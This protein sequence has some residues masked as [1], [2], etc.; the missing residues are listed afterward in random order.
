MQIQHSWESNQNTINRTYEN[1][2]DL[3]W[4]ILSPLSQKNKQRRNGLGIFPVL[5]YWY[6]VSENSDYAVNRSE[7]NIMD[8]SKSQEDSF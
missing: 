8:E 3:G 1:S 5:D 4:K 7:W 6:K 2:A